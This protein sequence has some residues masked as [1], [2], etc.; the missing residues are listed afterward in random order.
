MSTTG[1]MVSGGVDYEEEMPLPRHV[2]EGDLDDSLE[3]VRIAMQRLRDDTA[4]G[5]REIH[6]SV[7]ATAISVVSDETGELPSLLAKH[8]SIENIIS[9][10]TD[11]QL[12]LLDQ[13]FHT[14]MGNLEQR[15]TKAHAG[16]KMITLFRRMVEEVNSRH[17]DSERRMRH[18]EELVSQR[19]VSQPGLVGQEETVVIGGRQVSTSMVAVL[20]TI[21]ELETRVDVLTARAKHGGV[22]IGDKTFQS[23][24]EL[25][26]LWHKHDPAGNG[27][28][29]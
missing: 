7:R 22:S 16:T 18:L 2:D 25:Q 10:V 29:A 23:E 27:L 9:S 3:S 8:G 19:G 24:V 28:A 11:S 1:S 26:A 20:Q 15:V 4:R 5:F 6:D 21:R 17:E 13:S 14:A 12:R